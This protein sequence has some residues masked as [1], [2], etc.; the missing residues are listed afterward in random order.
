MTE[1]AKLAAINAAVAKDPELQKLVQ[2]SLSGDTTGVTSPFDTPQILLNL[3]LKSM[4]L[5]MPKAWTLD[6]AGQAKQQSW[7][8]RNMDWVMPLALIGGGLTAGALAGGG[9]GVATGAGATGAA[10]G[11]GSASVPALTAGFPSA[12]AI[13]PAA[14]TPS[15]WS[16]IAGPLISTGIPAATGL[17]GTK[18][19]V[20]ANKAASDATAKA[21]QDALDWEKQQYGV[22]QE[23]LAPTIG[24]GNAARLRLGDLM[25]LQAPEGGYHAPAVTQPN[26]VAVTN[27]PPVVPTSGTPAPAAPQMVTMKAPT[28]Q[29]SSVPADQVQHYQQL[30]AQV[31]A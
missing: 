18:M 29:V 5:E 12:A 15:L 22:R 20:D 8:Q 14:A 19:Q 9:A 28:G 30:G 3:R 26:G 17:I 25:G 27:A 4:G 21:A 16:K 24:V 11:A 7:F 23:Q 2:R 6:E 10:T 1:D 31:V 13:T